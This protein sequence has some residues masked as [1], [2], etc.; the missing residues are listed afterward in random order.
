MVVCPDAGCQQSG[1]VA[2]TRRLHLL[3]EEPHNGCLNLPQG[4]TTDVGEQQRFVTVAPGKRGHLDERPSSVL[5]QLRV[6]RPQRRVPVDD[7]LI[8]CQ[9]INVPPLMA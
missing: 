6:D 8:R 5:T 4:L 2:G 7:N 9:A 1:D 3:F